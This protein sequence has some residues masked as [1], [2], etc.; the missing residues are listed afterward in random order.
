MVKIKFAYCE[1]CK[2]EVAEPEK[3]PLNSMQRTIWVIICLG[4]LG[5]GVIGFLLYN[6]FSR[7]KNFCPTCHS[8]L[9]YSQEPFEKPK[10][11][12]EVLTA[13]QKVLKKAGRKKAKK[14]AA[15]RKPKKEEEKKEIYCPYC[16]I[17]LDEKL[18]TCPGCKTI[19]DWK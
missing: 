1:Y 13:K 15:K 19:L 4:T 3:K 14:P 9:T 8:R 2:K 10:E 16:G 5:F 11:L 7:K 17:E 18:A 12:A 6:K